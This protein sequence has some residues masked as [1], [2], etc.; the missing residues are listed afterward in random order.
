MRGIIYALLAMV[1]YS[2]TPT[3]TQVGYKGGIQTNTLLFSRHLVSFVFLLP[4]LLKKD[5]FSAIGKKQLPGILILCACSIVGNITF[6]YAYHYLP[7]MVA[8]SVS[9][10]YIVFVLI[11]E[12]IMGR[13]K[14]TRT[15]GVVILLTFISMVIIAFPGGSAGIDLKAFAVGLFASFMYSAQL[16][17][18]NS[19]I[20][21]SVPAN[22]LLLTSVV[23][24]MIVS[25]FWCIAG[26]QP[27]LPSNGT[28]WF[29]IL[30]LGTIGV[31]AARG[32]FYKAVRIIGAST[33]SIIDS[34]EP[35]SSA[36]LGYVLLRQMPTI[37]T[38]IGSLILC[39]SVILLLKERSKRSI[40][41][42]S[43]EA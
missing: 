17:F 27:L 20:M 16:V 34:L 39:F 41:S 36:V 18:I 19:R 1:S 10:S 9:L 2:S 38:A 30:C 40:L 7:N 5:S 35:F 26:G 13:E 33:A 25:F 22:I 6:N 37:F 12:L 14:Y 29:A 43:H 24:I 3:F 4:T 23:P 15:R 11:I 32:L 21:R 31:I 8:V 28:Q 42:E